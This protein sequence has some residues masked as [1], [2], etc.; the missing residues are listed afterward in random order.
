[1][2]REKQAILLVIPNGKRWHYIAVKTMS[3][4]ESNNVTKIMGFLLS[5]LSPLF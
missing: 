1:M 3:I 2:K 4:I 5:E